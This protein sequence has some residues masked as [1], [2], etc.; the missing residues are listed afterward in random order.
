MPLKTFVGD[1]W[2]CRKAQTAAAAGGCILLSAQSS[3]HSLQLAIS[4]DTATCCRCAL[5]LEGSDKQEQGRCCA[6]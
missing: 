5:Q 3:V 6:S 2:L 1:W 4:R